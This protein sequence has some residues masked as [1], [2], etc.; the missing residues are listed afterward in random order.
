MGIK[1]AG[2][3]LYQHLNGPDWFQT[4]GVADDGN[5]GGELYVYTA[6]R[7]HGSIPKNW[8]GYPVKI[9]YVGKVKPAGV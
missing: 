8:E 4:V 6:R 1:E 3:S 7:K 5:G 2:E 9:E